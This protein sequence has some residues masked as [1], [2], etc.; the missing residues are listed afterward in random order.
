MSKLLPLLAIA[1]VSAATS[2][3]CHKN[4]EGKGPMEAA[5]EKVDEGAHKTKEATEN[6]GEGVKDA[7]KGDGG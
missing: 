7:F 6:A 5:G 1:F 4:S 3:A 2:L